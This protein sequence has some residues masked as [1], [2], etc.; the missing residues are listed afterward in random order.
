MPT[1]AD[2]PTAAAMAGTEISVG[3]CLKKRTANGNG[4]VYVLRV[5]ALS[6]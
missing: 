5:G 4:T 2:T 1:A 6:V 3:Q